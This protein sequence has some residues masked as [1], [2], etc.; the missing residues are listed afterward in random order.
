MDELDWDAIGPAPVETP[1]LSPQGMEELALALGHDSYTYAQFMLI[2]WKLATIF[3]GDCD[4]IAGEFGKDDCLDMIGSYLVDESIADEATFLTALVI[5]ALRRRL[6]YLDRPLT[7]FNG[8][9]RIEKIK[10]AVSIET[11]AEKFTELRPVGP[12]RLKGKCPLHNEATPS[13]MVYT[14][15]QSWYC[16]GQCA[17]GGDIVTL[18]QLLEEA[19]RW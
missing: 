4:K 11:L 17:R 1:T 12:G 19:G 5:P 13:F 3:H 8:E 9:S 18:S 16:F 10:R 7:M 6:S 14:D 15:T 2:R